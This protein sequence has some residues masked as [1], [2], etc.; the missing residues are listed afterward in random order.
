VPNP[1]LLPDVYLFRETPVDLWGMS[2]PWLSY[3]VPAQSPRPLLTHLVGGCRRIPVLQRGSHFYCDLRVV[4]MTL[5][6]EGA[7]A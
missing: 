2:A 6:G 1:F 7:A 5:K 4:I 3:E